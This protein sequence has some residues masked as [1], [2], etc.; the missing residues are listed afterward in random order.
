M[1]FVLSMVM[2]ILDLPKIVLGT[3]IGSVVVIFVHLAFWWYSL[4]SIGDGLLSF[5]WGISRKSPALRG[6]VF[7]LLAILHFIALAI[8]MKWMMQHK[9]EIIAG[10]V[11]LIMLRHTFLL[12][13]CASSDTRDP[14]DKRRK[15]QSDGNPESMQESARDSDLH[16]RKPAYTFN[17]V[18]GMVA[19][20]Q[21]LLD[22]VDKHKSK[23]RANG[24][25]LTGDPGNGK[26]FIAEALAGELGWKFMP[27]SI[28]DIGSRW[29]GQTS[30]Q[31]KAVF[32]SAA[33]NTP[34]VLFF[35]ECDSMLT[36]RGNMMGGG[37]AGQDQL[38]TANTFLTGI[39]D[40]RRQ[41]N[42]IVI[43]AS[44]YLDQLDSAAI[45]DGRFDF[46]IEIP[47]PDKEA[48]RGLLQQFAKG[49]SFDS[50]VLERL[51]KR[52]EG[53]SVARMI[54]VSK[55]ISEEAKAQGRKSVDVQ[56][57]MAALRKVQ[58]SMGDMVAEDVPTLRDGKLHFDAGQLKRLDGLARRLEN[59]EEVERLG[60][61]APKGVL[62]YG[63]PGTG[64]TAVAKSLAKTSGWA[65]LATSGAALLKDSDEFKRILR[66]ARDLRPTIIFIDEAD[67]VLRDR[68][69]N[70]YGT[71]VTNLMLAEMDGT[72]SLNDIMFIAATNHP[73]TLDPAM[74]RSGRFGEHYE[75]K[76]PEDDTVLKM[77]TEW[78]NAKKTGTPFH[79]DFTP[80]AV[81]ARLSG[82][83]PSDIKGK[84][85]AAVDYGVGRMMIHD[86]IAKVTLADLEV[87]L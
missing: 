10:Y 32:D 14:M 27:I 66:K 26:T 41:K 51:S 24:I 18:H 9:H 59:I 29:I 65:F 23:E 2:S 17:D 36:D 57:A 75:F 28:G 61:Q 70:Q 52:W 82:M 15:I 58:G 55:R 43:A 86:G 31:L 33:R 71:A 64:K 62:F 87:V 35:D 83:S 16:V 13:I 78:I 46:K 37:S 6:V 56:Q 1:D 76:A 79:D 54:A 19:L 40:I 63:P 81:T 73:D 34:V 22:A 44:N 67:D 7:S 80:D 72:G 8:I 60:G 53:F 50:D 25:L 48:R 38:N 21:Q 45:R 30:E 39:V 49:V 85:Q 4:S 5:G 84:L 20:K 77:V 3:A 12:A 11:S 69:I 68:K 74:I 47:N 42:V